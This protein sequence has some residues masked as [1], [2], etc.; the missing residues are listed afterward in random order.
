MPAIVLI[1]ILLAACSGRSEEPDDDSTATP[2]GPE[3]TATEIGPT[4]TPQ[5][6]ATPAPTQ[7]PTAVPTL[8]PDV[9]DNPPDWEPQLVLSSPA[10]GQESLLDGAITLRFDQ[11]MDTGSV[12]EAFSIEPAV[13]GEI[14]WPRPDLM[15]F[16]PRDQLAT[17]QNYQVLVASTAKGSNGLF[18][19]EPLKL[20]VQTIGELNVSAVIPADGAADIDVDG[21]ITVLFNRPVV[22]LVATQDQA[23]LVNPI[24]V[25]PPLEGT[26]EWISTSIYRFTPTNGF[27]GATSYNVTVAAG[28]TDVTGAVLSDQVNSRFTTQQPRVENTVP[29]PNQSLWPLEGE[30]FELHFNMA[31]DPTNTENAISLNPAAPLSFEWHDNNTRVTISPTQ[32][33]D[34]ETSYT[35]TIDRSAT[36]A[37]GE[38]GLDQTT[39]IQFN[40]V[41]LPRVVRTEPNNG[42]QNARPY[43]VSFEFSAPIDWSTVEDRII[44]DP[45][46]DRVRYNFFDGEVWLWLNFPMKFNQDYTITIPGDV[47][48]PYGNTL[49]D[50]Y[51]LQFTTSEANP[52]VRFNLPH[53]INQFSAS[54]V[55]QI[56]VNHINAEQLELTLIDA[57]LPLQ[58]AFYGEFWDELP[59]ATVLKEWSVDPNEVQNEESTTRIDLSLNDDGQPLPTGVYMLTVTSPKFSDEPYRADRRL[60][61]VADTNLVVKETVDGVYVWATD[62]ASGQP[63]PGRLL[64]LYNERFEQV[65]TAETDGDGIAFFDVTRNYQY[66]EGFLAISETPGGA[67][68]GFAGTNWSQGAS[69]WELGHQCYKTV[70]KRLS[71]KAYLYTD[72]PLYRPGDTVEFK[73]DMCAIK[74]YGRYA[75]PS[76][77]TE[78]GHRRD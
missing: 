55:P 76:P 29:F 32:R 38:G 23:G 78:W 26:G 22:P 70:R 17:A 66:F 7:P 57:G 72:R 73:G 4:W 6:T 43:G 53:S 50:D 77:D 10:R 54:F 61:V 47:A 1:L 75:P 46:P 8:D 25:S 74:D 20:D 59:G 11:P 49:G 67:G 15:I 21:A 16:T 13:D 3:P 69:P 5:P 34:I 44:I 51:V 63:A 33:L 71:P 31:M 37:S 42:E 58:Q 18:L 60:L 48:D 39:N 56:D 41:P 27:A 45:E 28:L 36:A 40:T 19:R 9:I 65:G 35:L 14:Q 68:F 2:A 64:A 12:E 24:T 52:N 62:M 30:P